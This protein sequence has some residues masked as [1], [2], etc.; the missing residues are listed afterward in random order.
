VG[1]SRNAYSILMGCLKKRNNLKH[2]GID[3]ILLKL[4]LKKY[5]GWLGLD[6]FGSGRDRW[7]AVVDTAMNRAVV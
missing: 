3:R 5:V 4:A 6:L 7:R 1:K 2:L